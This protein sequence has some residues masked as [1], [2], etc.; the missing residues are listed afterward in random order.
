MSANELSDSL[1]DYF[2]DPSN[3]SPEEAKALQVI[4]RRLMKDIDDEVR[5]AFQFLKGERKAG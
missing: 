4:Q 3:I 5:E 2:D 1:L